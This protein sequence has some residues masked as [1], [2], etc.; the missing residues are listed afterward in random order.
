M[1][2]ARRGHRRIILCGGRAMLRGEP[3]VPEADL[4]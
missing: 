3:E 2:W 4:D 1:K